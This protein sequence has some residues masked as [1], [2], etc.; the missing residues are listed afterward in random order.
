M[1]LMPVAMP[2]PLMLL[3]PRPSELGPTHA[4]AQAHD[5]GRPWM[6]LHKRKGLKV[7]TSMSTQAPL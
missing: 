5:A 2:V 4:Q 6:G 1:P 3:V 7:K